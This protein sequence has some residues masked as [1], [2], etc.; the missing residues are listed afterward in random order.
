MVRLRIKGKGHGVLVFEEWRLLGCDAVW[1]RNVP[2]DGIPLD[3]TVYVLI[4]NVLD[5]QSYALMIR[6]LVLD[7]MSALVSSRT[8]VS[9][10]VVLQCKLFK[11]YETLKGFCQCL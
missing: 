9:V 5:F 2:E 6:S 3:I 11:L 1:L 4:M 10:S 7:R 8:G